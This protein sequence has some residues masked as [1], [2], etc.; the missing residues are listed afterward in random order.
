MD[1]FYGAMA[2]VRYAQTFDRN[3]VAAPPIA[4]WPFLE[5]SRITDNPAVAK[6]KRVLS[7]SKWCSLASI[8]YKAKLGADSKVMLQYGLTVH[9]RFPSHS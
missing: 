2:K 6:L 4:K 9:Y 1:I 5:T 3:G 7:I 8:S